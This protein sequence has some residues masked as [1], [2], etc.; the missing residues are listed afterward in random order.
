MINLVLALGE[1]LASTV[2]AALVI[3]GMALQAHA[4]ERQIYIST[5]GSRM[6]ATQAIGAAMS[7][8]EVYKCTLQVAA[9]SKS[10]TSIRVKNVPKKLTKEQIAAKIKALQERGE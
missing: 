9:V 1:A 8:H 7:G 10:G 2:I 6:S 5:N 3:F 4:S